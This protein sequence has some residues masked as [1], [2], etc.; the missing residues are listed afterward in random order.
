MSKMLGSDIVNMGILFCRL[1]QRSHCLLLHNCTH[2]IC[3]YD[4]T[5]YVVSTVMHLGPSFVDLHCVHSNDL[6]CHPASQFVFCQTTSD[7]WGS[8][9]DHLTEV[10]SLVTETVFVHAAHRKQIYFIPEPRVQ[11]CL[12]VVLTRLAPVGLEQ[13]LSNTPPTWQLPA[14]VA[15]VTKVARVR[16][17]LGW[18]GQLLVPL[19][20]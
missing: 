3:K 6:L 10:T 11:R 1:G 14:R 18:P 5:C 7:L 15:V 16:V 17:C 2:S 8:G 20:L 19:K 13:V 4:D 12:P 9:P